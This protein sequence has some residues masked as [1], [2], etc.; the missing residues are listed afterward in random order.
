MSLRSRK[1]LQ[2]QAQEK[3][4]QTQKDDLEKIVAAVPG[5][6]DEHGNRIEKSS[7]GAAGK[8]VQDVQTKSKKVS[9]F[10][11]MVEQ[12]SRERVEVNGQGFGES[13]NL[14]FIRIFFF[15]LVTYHL[16]QF[17]VQLKM[18]EAFD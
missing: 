14:E 10:E 2:L 4:P 15:V 12:L 11:F 16:N 8:G 3:A 17:S 5:E 13:E 6:K 7:E 1:I 18:K 9:F